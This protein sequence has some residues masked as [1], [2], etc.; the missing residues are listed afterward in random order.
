MKKIVRREETRFTMDGCRYRS[1]S[2]Y[3]HKPGLILVCRDV[4]TPDSVDRR[5]L[6]ASIQHTPGAHSPS[7]G[8]AKGS[9]LR[10]RLSST[11]TRKRGSKK[12]SADFSK[13]ASARA[14]VSMASILAY[15]SRCSAPGACAS[16]TCGTLERE[17]PDGAEL[18]INRKTG[19]VYVC[20]LCGLGLRRRVDRGACKR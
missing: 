9:S 2:W 16:S 7:P 12:V 13:R 17:G 5:C 4:A 18:Q 20:V 10:P 3:T 8:S 6:L 19:C 1:S 11:D 14:M 15:A